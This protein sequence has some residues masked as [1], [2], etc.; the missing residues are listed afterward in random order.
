MISTVMGEKVRG[1]VLAGR[2]VFGA[3]R[4][5]RMFAVETEGE[6]EGGEAPQ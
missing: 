6:R 2:R 1:L 4:V 3:R 5:N